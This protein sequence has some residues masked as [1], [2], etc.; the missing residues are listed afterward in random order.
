M[1]NL[2]S[3]LSKVRAFRQ[4]A[5]DVETEE[6]QTHLGDACDMA[7]KLGFPGE[8]K[9]TF[10]VST[11]NFEA[12]PLHLFAFSRYPDLWPT[13]IPFLVLVST[14]SEFALND[15]FVSLEVK[16]PLPLIPRGHEV[17]SRVRK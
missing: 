6:W 4:R 10:E 13:I 11:T 8:R 1:L 7:V 15:V 17:L 12:E 16:F 9:I 14:L 5:I 3:F 2:G